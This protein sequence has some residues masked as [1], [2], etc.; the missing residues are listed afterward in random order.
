MIVIVEKK[1]IENSDSEQ[2]VVGDMVFESRKDYDRFMIQKMASSIERKL[3]DLTSNKNSNTV[4]TSA[5]KEKIV[6]YLKSPESNAKNIRN[7]SIYMYHISS[8]YRR[9]INHYANLFK[10]E[11]IL[12]PYKLDTSNVNE[13]TFQKQYKKVLEY[14]ENMQIK[15]E[16]S[17][18]SKT[19]YREDVF[20]GICLE[21]KDN[22]YIQ[23]INPDYCKVS[24]VVDGVYNFAIDM[25]NIKEDDL[26][27]YPEVVTKL[28]NEYGDTGQK[29][30][31]VPIEDSACFK[32]NEDFEY[33]MPIFASVLPSL[34]DIED[35]KSLMKQRTAIGNYKVLSMEIPLAEDGTPLLDWD[36]AMDYYN[37]TS[38][39]LP[40]YV[41]SVISPMKLDSFNFDTNSGM[42]DSKKVTSVEE[43]FWSASGTSYL[44]FGGGEKNSSSSLLL[45]TKSDSDIVLSVA[46]QV[47]RWLNRRL[48]K[49]S[50]TYK[51]KLSFLPITTYNREEMTKIYQTAS[52]YGLPSKS[53]YCASI[54]LSPSDV[55]G[56]TY[57][58]NDYLQLHD[59][60]IPLSSS[61]TQ[62]GDSTNSDAG[63]PTNE[64]QG[65]T[66]SP[67]GE[68]TKENDEND[69]R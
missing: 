6:N 7:S 48:K 16:F 3:V 65:K 22:F 34:F 19:L 14:V 46:L 1:S 60:F 20:F 58:E 69:N 33:P 38:S 62:S 27:L 21:N 5:T 55:A 43:Q 59:K 45:S 49:L 2:Y 24:S 15:H 32:V 37:H 39:M 31:E 66:L 56:L 57:L 63:R 64:S 18:I 50:G 28:Y 29:W 25:S 23:K 44:L 67:S 54:G 17:K 35:Y 4:F 9:L 10:W 68:Q 52:T 8:H 42:E 40:D 13:K 51:F 36:I 26:A 12:V 30:Q 53:L 11:Y 47:E 61:H 41:G